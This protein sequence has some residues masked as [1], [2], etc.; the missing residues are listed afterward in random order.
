VRTTQGFAEILWR[1]ALANSAGPQRPA[2]DKLGDA[3]IARQLL[4]HAGV[5]G[6][7]APRGGSIQGSHNVL[8]L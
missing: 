5:T 2:A 7:L 4:K 8:L 3:W 1:T 6:D